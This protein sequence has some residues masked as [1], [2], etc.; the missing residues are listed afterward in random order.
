MIMRQQIV[1]CR[2]VR[3]TVHAGPQTAEVI[4]IDLISIGHVVIQ[5]GQSNIA[6]HI[7]FIGAMV[8]VTAFHNRVSSGLNH[9]KA[10]CSVLN[11]FEKLAAQNRTQKN[12]I[13]SIFLN[14]Q[15]AGSQVDNDTLRELDMVNTS[16]VIGIQELIVSHI[17]GCSRFLNTDDIASCIDVNT[18]AVGK[19]IYIGTAEDIIVLKIASQ[20]VHTGE[21]IIR[22][23]TGH[24]ACC[25]DV[26]V[27][28]GHRNGHRNTVF[29]QI[30][31]AC[32]VQCEVYA[33]SRAGY[34]ANFHP[35]VSRILHG[36]CRC[37]RHVCFCD[38]FSDQWLY[39]Q[40]NIS[41]GCHIHKTVYYIARS[42]TICKG[43]GINVGFFRTH[44]GCIGHSE[45]MCPDGGNLSVQCL[46][47]TGKRYIQNG[48]PRSQSSADFTGPAEFYRA[49]IEG[50][51]A[52]HL[53]I[54][55]A[56]GFHQQCRE[57]RVLEQFHTAGHDILINHAWQDITGVL[58]GDVA[59]N[60]LVIRTVGK[61]HR[62]DPCLIV[63]G[64]GTDGGAVCE[65]DITR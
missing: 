47:V 38:H 5:Q 44:A 53:H 9:A 32:H 58:H 39:K 64:Q 18:C 46:S 3:D 28:P 57:C 41:G 60:D 61:C 4:V 6:F 62:R 24:L 17:H 21:G 27:C 19:K 7:I 15:F 49:V 25:I 52:I 1:V 63:N 20:H 33:A 16:I 55:D 42:V 59:Q 40:M 22:H 11:G 30:E 37:I 51:E 14:N 50:Q 8:G 36:L 35:G 13:G 10:D 43:P 23:E 2:T 29:L 26:A 45:G 56:P 34:I 54:A 48:F 65:E 12:L 31:P